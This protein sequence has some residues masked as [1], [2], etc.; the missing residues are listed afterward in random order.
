MSRFA[1]ALVV[2]TL[3]GRPGGAGAVGPAAGDSLAR[4]V[5][6][7]ERRYVRLRELVSA[8][9]SARDRARFTDSVRAGRLLVRLAG[10][11]SRD[12]QPAADSVWKELFAFF[13]DR[14]AVL[15]GCPFGVQ[16]DTVP[17]PGRGRG[18]N[19]GRRV[20]VARRL[21]EVAGGSAASCQAGSASIEG[22][23]VVPLLVHLASEL[24]FITNDGEVRQWYGDAI[25]LPEPAR[26]RA[27]AFVS[28]ATTGAPAG[29]QCLG[30]APA[31]CADVL[32]LATD[33]LA[34]QRMYRP[35]AYR[36]L[37]LLL[38]LEF[39]GTPS[40]ELA[41]NDLCLVCETYIRDAV[42]SGRAV[43]SPLLTEARLA[44]LRLAVEA[45][46][47]GAFGRLESHAGRP[48]S[49][50]LAFASGIPM[51]SLL[52]LWRERLIAARPKPVTVTPADGWMAFSWAVLLLVGALRSSRW[53]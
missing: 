24:Q 18:S 34:Y 52:T 31:A 36:Q 41:R 32:G 21:P 53:R 13:G 11:T 26:E 37:A 33:S 6:S 51:D 40:A 8:R 14:T 28:L 22:G 47:P 2:A 4:V 20:L 45:G 38:G 27:R 19:A 25:P 9:T 23:S 35:E 12:I 1:L 29:Q 16:A 49:E 46:G 39:P 10:V 43:P 48:I 3:A 50:R 30:G 17:M 5:D 15:D 44:L 42:R 7:L